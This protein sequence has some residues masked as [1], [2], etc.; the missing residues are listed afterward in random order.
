[1]WASVDT[2][3]QRAQ[4]AAARGDPRTAI[5]EARIVLQTE[6][7]DLDTRRLLVQQLLQVGDPQDA[8]VELEQ[9]AKYRA[10]PPAIEKEADEVQLALG[11]AQ[12]L[13]ARLDHEQPGLAEVDRRLLRGRALNALSRFGEA[14]VEFERALQIA[15]NL[16]PARLGLIEAL[17][18]GRPPG[19]PAED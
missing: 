18:G 16:T 19:G 9:A 8:K 3:R 6:P 4:Q 10:A 7:A 13:L 2:H 17:A 1:M 14:T 5:I 12:A 11:E 15:S